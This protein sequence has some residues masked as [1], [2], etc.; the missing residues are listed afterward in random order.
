MAGAS[1]TPPS[2]RC[3][4][5]RASG[6]DLFRPL[7]AAAR[8]YLRAVENAKSQ[9]DT[10]GGNPGEW[11]D[12]A[13]VRL[14]AR[15]LG[16]ELSAF[17][18]PVGAVGVPVR[19]EDVLNARLTDAVYT[20]RRAYS[21]MQWEIFDRSD[22]DQA[23]RDRRD[24]E[25]HRGLAPRRLGKAF[26]SLPE[27]RFAV[28]RVGWVIEE[29]SPAIGVG[30]NAKRGQGEGDGGK[31]GEPLTAEQRKTAWESLRPCDRH[32]YLA[33]QYAESCIGK[34]LEDQEAHAY[35]RENGIETD[36]GE[37]GALVDYALPQFDSFA[38]YLR[39]ARGKLNEQ[40]YTGRAG[41]PTTKSI[42]PGDGIEYQKGDAV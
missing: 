5:I 34:R 6:I 41:R 31:S 29:P 11:K 39:N 38:K 24:L 3:E 13:A 2:D 25:V 22:L 28:E 27:L 8:N 17:F 42:V 16:C 26:E 9:V 10:A 1:D 19:L 4:P 40:K 20:L 18:D 36:N 30:T 15:H 33:F 14:S 37:L 21:R 12:H 35:L 7:L 23:E 32:A